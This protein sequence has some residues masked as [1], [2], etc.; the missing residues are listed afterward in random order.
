MDPDAP[1]ATLVELARSGDQAGWDGIVDRYGPVVLAV[2]RRF[3]LSE[4][5]IADVRQTVWLRLLENLGSLRTAEALPG[6]LVT[7]TRRECLRVRR[8]GQ[9][10]ESLP[11]R[12]EPPDLTDTGVDEGLLRAERQ[13]ALRAAFAD[14]P[15]RSQELLRLLISDPPVPYEEISRRLGIPV[16]G[17]GP[18]R[19]RCLKKL[20]ESSVLT[21]L[22]RDVDAEPV[23]DR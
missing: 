7:T 10:T 14:L 6:W 3:R 8:S 19:A 21:A 2:C 23:R 1:V 18:T 22:T 9:R 13:A 16:G 20:R 11:E 4:A 17:I 5:D 12:Y 15:P